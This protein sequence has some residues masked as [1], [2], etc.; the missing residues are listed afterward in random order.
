MIPLPETPN[1]SIF[2]AVPSNIGIDYQQVVKNDRFIPMPDLDAIDR[3]ILG[4][5]QNDSRLTM[6][7]L[8][9]KV[10]L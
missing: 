5:L 9:D 2:R 7:E 4:Y 1:F 6:Q 8:A 10:G 3:K